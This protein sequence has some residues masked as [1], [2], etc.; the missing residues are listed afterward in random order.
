MADTRDLPMR[1]ALPLALACV[2]ALPASCVAQS[3][4]LPQVR[5]GWVRLSPAGMPMLAGFGR[6]DNACRTPAAIMAADSPAF[7]SVELHESRLVDGVSRMR[8]VGELRIAAHGEADME[9]GGL[10]LMLMRP[11]K[12]LEVGDSVEMAFRLADGRT[13]RGVFEVRAPDAR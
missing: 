1:L 6:I 3:D 11:A 13:L 5:D 2:A 12:P 4:C 9:P 10:H 7:G 8:A